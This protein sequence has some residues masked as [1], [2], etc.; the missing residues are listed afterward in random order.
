MSKKK[1]GRVA[2]TDER[3]MFSRPG[4]AR[5]K[6]KRLLEQAWYEAYKLRGSDDDEGAL[7]AFQR[8]VELSGDDDSAV[9]SAAQNNMGELY[10]SLGNNRMARKCFERS[11]AIEPND[12]LVLI[13]LG[14]ALSNLGEYAHAL[15]I[16]ERAEALKP[17]KPA[18]LLLHS[19]IGSTLIKLERLADA[20]K[21][22]DRFL[23]LDKLGAPCSRSR[24]LR[25][26]VLQQKASI[27]TILSNRSAGLDIVAVHLPAGK[28]GVHSWA[29]YEYCAG[30]GEKSTSLQMC[31][32][33]G[34]LRFCGKACQ[35]IA[36]KAGH[37]G[38]CGKPIPTIDQLK[39][40]T[41]KE[42]LAHLREHQAGHASLAISCLHRL[43]F[44]LEDEV[45]T[46]ED[47]SA[48]IDVTKTAMDTH[49]LNSLVQDTGAL[50]LKQ[51]ETQLVKMNGG[52]EAE[53]DVAIMDTIQDMLKMLSVE[54]LKQTIA[55][56]GLSSDDCIEK[57]ELQAR[58]LE[59]ICIMEMRKGTTPGSDSEA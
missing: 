33:C 29:S 24:T 13:N 42:T 20:S 11:L 4:V 59:A 43:A 53:V 5:S 15:T 31:S 36:W 9:V 22:F 39:T 52:S 3:E 1:L 37:K 23:S 57:E 51:L 14:G 27:D 19:N 40:A 45:L 26:K 49:K 54:Q 41:P 46:V 18:A 7:R 2:V 30:C 56:A 21:R 25:N 16:F 48:M 6:N 12:P 34:I 47:I 44:T 10:G 32:G 35:R 58:A 17:E 8:C 50:A 28:W 55:Q 38:S